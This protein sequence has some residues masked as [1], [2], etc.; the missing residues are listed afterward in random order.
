LASGGRQNGDQM[1]VN[2][3][4]KLAGRADQ[5][6]GEP[7]DGPALFRP[8]IARETLRSASRSV[9]RKTCWPKRNRLNLRDMKPGSF[10]ASLS[11]VA[12]AL[13]FVWKNS[14]AQFADCLIGAR[15]GT[16]FCPTCSG[17]G[18][19]TL[20]RGAQDGSRPPVCPPA[21]RAGSVFGRVRSG[22]VTRNCGATTRKYR[23]ERASTLRDDELSL[24][25]R[26][27]EPG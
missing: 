9:S 10:A 11:K 18:G 7:A 1:Q 14:S 20:S 24:S 8:D 4:L 16:R 21:P 2:K 19:P 27:R 3:I 13:L 22:N 23:N 25:G 6:C 5:H 15:Y 17:C 12:V 26:S